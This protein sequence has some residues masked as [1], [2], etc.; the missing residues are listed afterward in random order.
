V[1]VYTRP[2][3]STEVNNLFRCDNPGGY[4]TCRWQFYCRFQTNE[5]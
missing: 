1:K 5:S 3:N 4:G 2:L